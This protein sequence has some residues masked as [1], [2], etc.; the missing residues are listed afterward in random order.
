MSGEDFAELETRIQEDITFFNGEMPAKNALA[1]NGYLA[2]L[3]E[4]GV[5]EVAQYYKL[6]AQLPAAEDNII[7]T[8]LLG[9]DSDE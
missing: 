5:L 1:W 4:W 9:R 6:Q 3:L 2:G 8:I 7:Q